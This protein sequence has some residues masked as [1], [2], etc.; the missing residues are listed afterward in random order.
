MSVNEPAAVGRSKN[1]ERTLGHPG[2]E[3]TPN[4]TAA[5]NTTVDTSATR[6]D[7]RARERR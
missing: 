1:A 3:V 2:D 5:A 7:R 6:V 4:H